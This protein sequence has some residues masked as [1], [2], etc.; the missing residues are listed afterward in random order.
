MRRIL[1]IFC[2]AAIHTSLVA[3]SQDSIA[4]RKFYNEN[5]I[6]WTGSWSHYYQNNKTYPLKQLGD[7]V[8]FSPQALL[9][10][11][12]YRKD[13]RVTIVL[14]TMS[15]SLLVSSVLVNDRNTKIVLAGGAVL[16][17]TIGIPFAKGWT[18]HL[19]KTIWIHNRDMLTR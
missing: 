5:A 9:E 6:L 14:F 2:L 1:T 7:V 16:T 13:R 3:Q 15:T 19:S 10:Y 12:E 4:I 11:Q 17:A 8:K 18:S